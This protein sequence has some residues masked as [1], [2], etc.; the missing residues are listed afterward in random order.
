MN[1]KFIF[2]DIDDTLY[3][4]LIPFKKAVNT[5]FDKYNLNIEEFFK[6]SRK[7]SDEVFY[8]TESNKMSTDDMHI[9]RVKKAL[10]N[11][12]VFIDDETALDFQKEYSNNQ[13]DIK[14]STNMEKIL[15]YLVSK[16]ISIGLLS[17]GPSKHQRMK[18][19]SLGLERFIE[20]EN[21]FISSEVGFAKPDIRIFKLVHERL[22]LNPTIDNIYFIGDSLKNDIIPANKMNWF[23][24]WIDRRDRR[25]ANNINIPKYIVRDDIELYN[26]LINKITI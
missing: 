17:N 9:Y 14:I 18:I 2:F 11:Q 13:F 16:N 26:L 15:K 25:N 4:Q 6:L 12:G 20:E 21:I 23:S 5:K 24:I 19:K 1:R 22:T 8:L 3:D 7:L 10:E